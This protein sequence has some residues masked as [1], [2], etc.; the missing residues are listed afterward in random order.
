[1]RL[2]SLICIAL[3]TLLGAQGLPKIDYE[4]VTAFQPTQVVVR[5][6]SAPP[7]ANQIANDPVNV[8]LLALLGT[9]VL[10]ALLV[11]GKRGA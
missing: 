8:M 2:V 5:D 10:I 1:M 3:P 4:G 6:Q 9:L 7:L 11:I